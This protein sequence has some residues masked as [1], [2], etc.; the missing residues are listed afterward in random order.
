[1]RTDMV[2][3][4]ACYQRSPLLAPGASRVLRLFL[5][6]NSGSTSAWSGFG[7]PQPPCGVYSLRLGVSQ[8]GALAVVLA[9]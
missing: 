7:D 2:Q 6:L 8:Q 4:L 1:M 9:Q 3:A 5:P